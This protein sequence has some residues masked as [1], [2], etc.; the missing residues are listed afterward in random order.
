[1]DKAA[2]SNVENNILLSQKSRKIP[3]Q[4]R[5]NPIQTD[6]VP[7]PR[8]LDSSRPNPERSQNVHPAGLDLSPTRAAVANHEEKVQ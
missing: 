3:K 7:N 1:V 5:E 8:F 6:P 2:K 4:S